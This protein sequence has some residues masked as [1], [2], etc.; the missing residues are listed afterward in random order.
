MSHESTPSSRYDSMPSN[1]SGFAS[2]ARPRI[3]D[4]SSMQCATRTERSRRK[5]PNC[6]RQRL[7]RAMRARCSMGNGS[8]NS[9]QSVLPL[10]RVRTGSARRRKHLRDELQMRRLRWRHA[11]ARVRRTRMRS[12]VRATSMPPHSIENVPRLPTSTRLSSPASGRER[13]SSR[14][15]WAPLPMGTLPAQTQLSASSRTCVPSSSVRAS[16][17]ASRPRRT[18]SSWPPHSPPCAMPRPAPPRSLR[19][20]PCCAPSSVSSARLRPRPTPSARV[21]SRSCARWRAQWSASAGSCNTH[22][23]ARPSWGRACANSPARM[24]SCRRVHVR[25]CWR[26]QRRTTW[27]WRPSR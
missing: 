13:Q 7:R 6:A 21:R 19:P 11:G 5:L 27:R 14:S 24:R 8:T 17:T 3:C 10:P 15:G 22:A 16:R 2:T 25:N 9:R 12:S 26:R 4:A 23:R 1:A 20:R 18:P